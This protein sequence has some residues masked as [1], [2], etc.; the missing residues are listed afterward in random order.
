MEGLCVF[1]AMWEGV[2][3]QSLQS[4]FPHGGRGVSHRSVCHAKLCGCVPGLANGL[5]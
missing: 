4:Q 5:G 3:K 2:L 1:M